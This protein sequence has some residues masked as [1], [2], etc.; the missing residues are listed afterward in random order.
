VIGYGEAGYLQRLKRFC[1]ELK[2]DSHVEFLGFLSPEEV[3]TEMERAAVLVLP[4]YMETSPN[5]VA[6]A[7][8]AGVPVVSTKVGGIPFM[9]KDG[10]TGLLNSPGDL[11]GLS[12][13][14]ARLLN[15]DG[16]RRKLGSAGKVEARKRYLPEAIVKKLL[17]A[18]EEILSAGLEKQLS[19]EIPHNIRTIAN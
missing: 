6:E 17:N 19:N 1:K 13:N 7:M 12:E 16:L 14:I 2:I 4:S 3:V 10:V 11:A 15:D 18:Y 9:V 8:A 5:C